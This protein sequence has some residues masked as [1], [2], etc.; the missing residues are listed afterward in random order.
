[1][2]P[3]PPR[4][5]K[6]LKEFLSI[7]S[8]GDFNIGVFSRLEFQK[9]QHT[10]IEALKTLRDHSIPAKLYVVGHVM[11]EDYKESLVKRIN[12]LQLNSDVCFK[13]FISNPTLAME[14]LD[15]LVLPSRNEA[16][17]LVLIEAMRCGVVVLGVNAGGVPEIIDHEKTGLLFEWENAEQLAEQL[18]FL[19]QNPVQRKTMAERGRAKAEREFDSDMHFEKLETLFK[20]E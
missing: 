9:G 10:L 16:F 11:Y 17:G 13:G 3:P 14:G 18:R 1:V 20:V 2:T 12:E 8:P 19:Y 6:F 4:D 15:A 7:S 5:E